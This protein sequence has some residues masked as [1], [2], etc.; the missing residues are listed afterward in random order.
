M[1]ETRLS[2]FLTDSVTHTNRL[3]VACFFLYYSTE[4][5][6]YTTEPSLCADPS[7]DVIIGSMNGTSFVFKGSFYWKLIKDHKRIKIASGYP[8][9]I[10]E[11]I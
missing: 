11:S 6:H 1:Q 10:K 7:F 2:I 5:V 9:K 4:P 3:K 8:R